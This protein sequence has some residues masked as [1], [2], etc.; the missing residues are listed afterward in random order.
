MLVRDAQ[1]AKAV[2]LGQIRSDAHLSGGCIAR[3]N[4]VR[5]ERQYHA[6][7]T[8]AFVRACVAFAPAGKGGVVGIFDLPEINIV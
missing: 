8:G 4:V 2:T 7:V 5:F 1:F 6:G 3:R